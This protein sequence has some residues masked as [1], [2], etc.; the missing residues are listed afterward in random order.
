MDS[1]LKIK[2]LGCILI[3]SDVLK[4]VNLDKILKFDLDY[5]ELKCIRTSPNYLNQLWK[6]VYAMNRQLRPPTFFGKIHNMHQ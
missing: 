1:H 3:V 6:D 5:K 4:N 2:L